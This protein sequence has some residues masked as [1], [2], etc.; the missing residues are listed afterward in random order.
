MSEYTRPPQHEI[1]IAR[2][3]RKLA[4]ARARRNHLAAQL[5]AIQKTLSDH[6]CANT[7][8]AA[9]H[10]QKMVCEFSREKQSHK[11]EM[12]REKAALFDEAKKLGLESGLRRTP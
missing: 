8:S 1:E 10:W 7:M 6:A 2:L 11:V 4:H 9:K 3:K 12:D 5:L